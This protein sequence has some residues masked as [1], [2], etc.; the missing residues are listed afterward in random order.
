[1]TD[2]ITFLFNRWETLLTN[3]QTAY[4]ADASLKKISTLTR[5]E[6]NN[7]ISVILES[8]EQQS[9]DQPI[10]TDPILAATSS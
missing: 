8:L 7:L 2:L 9:L 3:W 6:F 1:M 10:Q 4:G 5:A